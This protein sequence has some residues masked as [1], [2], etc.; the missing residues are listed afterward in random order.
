[1]EGAKLALKNE[2]SNTKDVRNGEYWYLGKFMVIMGDN[3][4]LTL[5]EVVRPLQRSLDCK[6]EVR[7]PHR[8]LS[9]GT[10]DHPFQCSRDSPLSSGRTFVCNRS[11][12][13]LFYDH[14]R[15][16]LVEVKSNS[17][18]PVAS[19]WERSLFPSFSGFFIFWKRQ[20]KI[21]VLFRRPSQGIEI[22]CKGNEMLK[23][24]MN[25]TYLQ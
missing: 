7:E 9:K 18:T 8:L 5:T 1:M 4:L 20:N 6:K 15:E 3:F 16:K 10:S 17:N 25:S 2:K 21:R 12:Y 19:V 11:R 13:T 14:V 23:Y 22:N 24:W